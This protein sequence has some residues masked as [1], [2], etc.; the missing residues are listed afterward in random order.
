MR[1]IRFVRYLTKQV[2]LFI[3]FD[4]CSKLIKTIFIYITLTSLQKSRKH[5]Y[6]LKRQKKS[7]GSSE[8]LKD[9]IRIK[10]AKTIRQM[11]RFEFVVS[12]FLLNIIQEN[13]IPYEK[14]IASCIRL[15]VVQDICMVY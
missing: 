7:I 11:H 15:V 2:K 12:F 4:I 5:N 14:D 13:V 6:F 9:I 8:I 10:T 1:D 3:I